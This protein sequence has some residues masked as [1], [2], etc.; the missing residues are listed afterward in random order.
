MTSL[1]RSEE[2]RTPSV[3]V[4]IPALDE[5]GAIH[6]VVSEVLGLRD[7]DGRAWVRRVIVADNGSRDRTGERARTAGA[8]VVVAARRGYGSACL[9]GLA[10]LK[11]DPP[12]I[13]AFIDGDGSSDPTELPEIVR[14]MVREEADLVIG[15]RVRNAQPG[16][17]T[18]P[19]RF[20]NVLATQ[21]MNRVHGS[22]FSDLG[23]F[24]AIR[25]PALQRLEMQDP[26]Y[27]W[28]VEMQLK[29]ARLGLS[30]VEVDVSHR[31]RAAGRSK[32]AGTVRGVLGAGG[33]ILW[34]LWRHRYR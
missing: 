5:E 12:D 18:W 21:I 29:A 7:S 13:V 19:Q 23:P 2:A 33:K 1:Q 11:H 30:T 14:V 17:L 32:V 3:D 31:V 4:V 15:S 8:E 27:G 25:W 34:V 24:R 20:G 9:V 16:A 6:A 10:A 28:T 26:D 22:S